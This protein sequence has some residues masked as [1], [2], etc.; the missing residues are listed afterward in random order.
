MASLKDLRVRINSVKN[1]RKITSAMKM[2]AASKLRRAQD[3]AE[4]GRPYAERMGRMLAGLAVSVAGSSGAPK[5]L[6]GTGRDDV[7]LVV[8][9][10]AD[11]GLCG[12][13]NANVVRSARN[14]I[15]DLIAAGKTVKVLCIGRKGRDALRREYAGLIIGTREG[16]TRRGAEFGSAND[17]AQTILS[18]FDAGQFDVCTVIYNKFRSA[19]SQEVTRQQLVPFSPPEVPSPE[20]STSGVARPVYEYEP[21]EEEILADLLPRNVAMQVFSALLESD[22]SEQGARMSAMDNATRNAGDMINKLTLVYNRTRQ[23][24]ITKELIEIISGAE[25]I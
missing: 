15:R 2:V 1:T 13:F 12:G 5:L 6:A 8:L 17:V 19:I 9:M 3:A 22:A 18:M 4:A 23:A 10:T 25:A 24:M 20:S 11:R 7:H 21:G 16:M 14:M